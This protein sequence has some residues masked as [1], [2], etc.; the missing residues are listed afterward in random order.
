MTG[1]NKLVGGALALTIAAE[2]CHGIFS[3]VWIGLHG[4][5]YLNYLT[6]RV[7]TYLFLV[8]PF[9]EIDLDP[10]KVC[11]NKEWK[12]GELLVN[13]LS[14]FFGTP[15]PF[16]LQHCFT[17]EFW[18]ASHSTY[19]M[20]WHLRFPCVLDHSDHSQEIN[21]EQTSGHA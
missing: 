15:S 4:R 19:P 6:V 2:C 12:I 10:F 17:Q 7:R 20:S 3:I 9:P 1:R 11:I 18:R 5:K 21:A 16:S 14:T 13:N 8:A